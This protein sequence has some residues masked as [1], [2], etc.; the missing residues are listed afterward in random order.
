[1]RRKPF[2]EVLA[3]AIVLGLSGV[4]C[5]H[6][7]AEENSIAAGWEYTYKVLEDNTA[8]ITGFEYK[9]EDESY[10]ESDGLQYIS[11]EIPGEIDSH[12]VSGIAKEAFRYYLISKHKC[13][14]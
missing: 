7:R 5:V 9:W 3:A 1:M 4:A 14:N 6:V 13:V 10:S 2:C 12:I 11:L 8:E